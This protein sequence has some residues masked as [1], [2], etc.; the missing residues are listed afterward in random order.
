[1]VIVVLLALGR[2]ATVIDTNQALQ[3]VTGPLAPL[4]RDDPSVQARIGAACDTAQQVV[5]GERG[6]QGLR[7]LQGI[8]GIDGSDGI[9]G[10]AGQP[11]TPGTPGQAGP[12]GAPGTPGEEGA[13]GQP[14]TDGVDGQPGSPG[15][16]GTPGAPG[17]DGVPGPACPD[18][19]EPEDV[20]LEN[21]TII[22]ACVISRGS[23]ESDA[24]ADPEMGE[25]LG[26]VL[27]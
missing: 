2:S 23:A 10:A 11:G 25:P 15:A 9:D 24:G 16:S 19:I 22:R 3:E 7:G 12:S 27:R 17:R 14:G 21:G 13:E 4:C 18:G 6:Q 26:L 5:Q 20:T 8:A 1:M